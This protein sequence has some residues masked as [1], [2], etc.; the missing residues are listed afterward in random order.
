[1]MDKN[2][3]AVR[4]GMDMQ[5]MVLDLMRYADI[6]SEL[7]D[8][9]KIALKPN[10]VVA[11]EPSNGATTH[12]EILEGVLMYLQESGEYDIA[13]ME[14][15]WVGDNTRRT[16][17]VCGYDTLAQKYGVK[18]LDLKKDTFHIYKGIRVCDAPM[19]ADYLINLPVLKGHCQTTMT[20]ALKNMKGTLPDAEKRRFHAEGLHVPIATLGTII[21]PNVTI[22]DGICGD[23]DFEEGGNPIPMNRIL[24]GFDS[25][26]IDTCVCRM[27]GIDTD[28]VP[29]IK[30]AAQF[31]AGSMDFTDDT[32]IELNDAS[33]AGRL[34]VR[35]RKAKALARYTDEREACSACYG[36][37]IHALNRLDE[38]G[39]LGWLNEKICIGQGFRGVEGCPLGVGNCTKGCKDSLK[40]C[41]PRADQIMEFLMDHMG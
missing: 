7:K 41:P 10:L 22:V 13:I 37:L 5:Q 39:R 3:I 12:T 16:M 34:P 26:L 32:L 35:S 38:M 2:K 40:G 28:E 31:G 36:S 6:K 24:L 23:L 8:G 1:M 20:C 11:S 15:S 19:N 33:N 18:T 14:G 29:Y 27:M 17:R 25:V 21:K 4:Y 30:L 9:M